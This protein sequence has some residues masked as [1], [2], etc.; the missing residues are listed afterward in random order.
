MQPFARVGAVGAA[1]ACLL[2]AAYAGVGRGIAG[3][4]AAVGSVREAC[5]RMGF[6]PSGEA[7]TSFQGDQALAWASQRVAPAL[8]LASGDS[9]A[10]LWK[11]VFAG[12][13]EGAA[14]V[15]GAVWAARRPVPENAGGNVFPAAVPEAA[16]GRLVAVLPEAERWS[17]QATQSW[18]EGDLIWH[19]VR[20][21]PSCPVLPAGWESWVE[22]EMAGSTLISFQH[23]TQPAAADVGVVMGRIAELE[24]VRSVSILA[25][26]LALVATLLA[27]AEHVALRRL[28]ALPAG[29]AVGGVTWLAG[30]AAALPTWERALGAVLAGA[31]VGLL[32]QPSRARRGRLVAGPIGV[33]TALGLSFLPGWVAGMGG[34]LP[35]RAPLQGD[36]GPLALL[37]S[38]WFPALAE[39][40]VLRGAVPL[41]LEPIGGWWGGAV[42]GAMVG[43]PLHAVPGVPLT[44]SLLAEWGLNLAM[45]MA[46]RWGGLPAAVLARGVCEGLLRRPGLAAGAGPDAVVLIGVVV[47]VAAE[48]LG[49]PRQRP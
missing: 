28:V 39:E 25:L 40:P 31:V 6:S 10:M 13:G 32:P 9:G 16:R 23:R 44:A 2:V 26:T 11:V 15:E 45:V 4:E 18:R 3:R 41:L 33:A 19:R 14:T 24:V 37:G 43:A 17:W 34:W 12:G 42:V 49:R 47:A 1:A 8:G 36:A 27:G 5:E 29:V 48:L 22:V 35:P 20:F 30:T 21:L 38:A 7:T 46:A